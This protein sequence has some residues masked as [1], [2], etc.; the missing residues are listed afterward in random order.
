ML[1]QV[2]VS[3]TL[4]LDQSPKLQR[5][6]P[7][8]VSNAI[9]QVWGWRWG[10][11]LE[12]TSTVPSSEPWQVLA[13]LLPEALRCYPF[14]HEER[15]LKTMAVSARWQDLR[16]RCCVVFLSSLVQGKLEVSG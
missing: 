11:S 12:V 15:L 16:F 10:V 8:L 13:H 2:S 14:S 1:T 5:S 6:N 9:Y 4:N 7:E 3:P